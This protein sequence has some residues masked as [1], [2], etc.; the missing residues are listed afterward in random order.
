[1]SLLTHEFSHDHF[2][3]LGLPLELR[4]RIM[5]ILFQTKRGRLRPFSVHDLGETMSGLQILRVCKQI[6]VEGIMTL[7]RFNAINFDYNITRPPR[8]LEQYDHMITHFSRIKINTTLNKWY[9]RADSRSKTDPSGMLR[10]VAQLLQTVNAPGGL[11][12][13]P[14]P[15][16]LEITLQFNARFHGTRRASAQ[17]RNL[18]LFHPEQRFWQADSSST[19]SYVYR[20]GFLKSQLAHAVAK[21]RSSVAHLQHVSLI[22][23]VED[24]GSQIEYLRIDDF[25]VKFRDPHRNI[26]GI[27]TLRDAKAARQEDIII[28]MKPD[29]PHCRMADIQ[30]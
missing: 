22:T 30:F 7:R 26:V 20:L 27:M 13:I 5:E 9:I 11:P 4:S 17:N 3:F 16:K 18:D 29:Q 8:S 14:Q 12:N 2:D 19:R 10:R 21:H 23:N 6:H 28:R 1:L 24:F 25:S 15:T